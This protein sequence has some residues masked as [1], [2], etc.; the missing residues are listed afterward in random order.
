MNT[1][2]TL[3]ELKIS[4]DNL[5]DEVKNAIYV[6]RGYAKESLHDSIMPA[7]ILK[8]LLHKLVII[9]NRKRRNGWYRTGW[10]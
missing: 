3:D 5:S 6:A 10:K 9:N 2:N 7:H 8:A 4:Q 1:Y